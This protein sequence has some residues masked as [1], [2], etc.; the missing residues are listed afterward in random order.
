MKD[1]KMIQKYSPY[2]QM[3]YHY[4]ILKKKTSAELLEEPNNRHY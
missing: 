1:P 3:T 2:L 4:K